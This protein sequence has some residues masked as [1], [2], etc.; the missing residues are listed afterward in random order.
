M[1][2]GSF[3]AWQGYS[4]RVFWLS[5]AAAS[6]A[7]LHLMG[8]AF[9]FLNLGGLEWNLHIRVKS[10]EKKIFIRWIQRR[11]RCCTF[12]VCW[13]FSFPGEVWVLKQAWALQGPTGMVVSEMSGVICAGRDEAGLPPPGIFQE[14]AALEKRRETR[15][16]ASSLSCCSLHPALPQPVPLI[17]GAPLETLS[18][19]VPT[20]LP[21]VPASCCPSRPE[22]ILDRPGWK[23]DQQSL[24]PPPP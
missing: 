1:D 20:S 23:I 9:H 21:Q 14:E 18:Q 19:S 13:S 8:L 22:L 2:L 17:L 4:R 6:I 12:P 24:R 11:R 15:A 10:V 16:A 5:R 3:W 7:C